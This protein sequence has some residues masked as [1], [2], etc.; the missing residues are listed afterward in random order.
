MNFVCE[1]C[2]FKSDNKQNYTRHCQTKKH[3]KLCGECVEPVVTESITLEKMNYELRIRELEISLKY[4]KERNESLEKKN[5]LLLSLLSKQP[6][7]V[8][9]QQKQIEKEIPV[10]IV[11]KAETI[12]EPMPK[13]KTKFELLPAI[14]NTETTIESTPKMEIKPKTDRKPKNLKDFVENKCVIENNKFQNFISKINEKITN[15]DINLLLGKRMGKMEYA[16][17]LIQEVY[18]LYDKYNKP[19]YN[20]D[21]YHKKCY[22][23]SKH[24][25]WVK[26]DISD[27]IFFL[28]EKI[29][30]IILAK[31]EEMG[32]ISRFTD[33]MLQQWITDNP[34][35]LEYPPY[36][37]GCYIENQAFK[38]INLLEYDDYDVY[39]EACINKFNDIIYISKEEM[40]E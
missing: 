3:L 32:R 15:H 38:S 12:S 29:N 30:N 23:I 28:I 9:E 21:K 8:V 4:E 2:D 24:G 35:T 1:T 6:V 13:T 19:Y 26:E 5:D 40:N 36:R 10:E 7:V 11:A 27:N 18:N 39:I 17:K 33:E 37:L 31:A 34:G 22:C 25:N 14:V 20:D 16:F